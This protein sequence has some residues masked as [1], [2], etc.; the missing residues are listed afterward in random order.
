MQ[1]SPRNMT[2]RFF[3]I[4]ILG[5][6]VLAPVLAGSTPALSL[7]QVAV[8]VQGNRTC[9]VVLTTADQS[10]AALQFDLQ[11]PDQ[12]VNIA[13]SLGS[14]ATLA[15]KSLWMSIPQPATKRFLIAG[16]NAASFSDGAV[17]TLSIQVAPGT[18]PGLYALSLTN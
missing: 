11:Y 4:C 15:R 3:T 10:I 7:G 17:I 12:T 2:A 1:P 5:V 13:G 8:D 14:A 6:G 16:F 9:A 18:L